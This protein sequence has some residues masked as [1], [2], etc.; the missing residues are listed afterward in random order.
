MPS[1]SKPTLRRGE[2]ERPRSFVRAT[3]DGE[4]PF[5]GPGPVDGPGGPGGA[6]GPGGAGGP[7][8]GLCSARGCGL[9]RMGGKA[10]LVRARG[11]VLRDVGGVRSWCMCVGCG[12]LVDIWG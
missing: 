3:A 8:L 5:E 7:G 11:D 6:E 2:R 9:V 10:G 4:T 1:V 12:G